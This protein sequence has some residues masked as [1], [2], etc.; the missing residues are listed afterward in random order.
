[1]DMKHFIE[2]YNRDGFRL[3]MTTLE[4]GSVGPSRERNNKNRAILFEELGIAAD[5]VYF[6]DQQH[7]RNV[8]T[9]EEWSDKPLIQ[10]DGLVSGNSRDMIA[11]TAADCMPIYLYDASKSIRAVLHSGWKGTGIAENAI[12]LMRERYSCRASDITAVLGPAIGSC[13]Y[14]VDVQRAEEFGRDWGNESVVISEGRFYLSLRDA[15]RKLLEEAG[16]GEII[17]VD[18]CTCCEESLG[19][20]RRE[21]PED[22][23]LMFCLSYLSNG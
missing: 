19:S 4:A 10:A 17:S 11:V 14:E 20:Y 21:G 18:R 13:C 3:I 16:V 15:N 23:T 22:F 12:N 7:T 9:T 2:L 5:D 8:I 6:A 1:M